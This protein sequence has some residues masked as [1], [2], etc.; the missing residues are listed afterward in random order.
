MNGQEDRPDNVTARETPVAEAPR[1][2]A[3]YEGPAPQ[4]PPAY[5]PPAAEPRA[6]APAQDPRTKSAPLACVLSALPGL[7]QVY[8]GYYQRGFVHAIVAA[9]LVTLISTGDLDELTPLAALFM[10]FFWLYNII[11]A[12]RRASMYNQVLAGGQL[13][14][15]PS[16]FQMPGIGGS[17]FGGLLLIGIGFVLLMHTRFDMPLVFMADWWPV[18]PMLFGVY[19]V[20][21]AVQEK[22]ATKS[23]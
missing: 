8:V 7:G 11:D 5:G 6:G 16:D 12:G 2:S 23:D 15:M 18:I 21:R 13:P 1:A 10:A 4:P 14:D 20:F 3:G 19:L 17:I 9:S 22:A